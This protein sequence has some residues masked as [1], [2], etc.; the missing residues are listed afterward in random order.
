MRF[1]VEKTGRQGEREFLH[2]T[3]GP[4]ERL[5]DL[6]CFAYIFA[7]GHVYV[8]YLPEPKLPYILKGKTELRPGLCGGLASKISNTL[9]KDPIQRSLHRE[10]AGK[11]LPVGSLQ[12]LPVALS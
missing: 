8:Q 10:S 3:L 9:R 1:S 11:P 4:D 2:H 12:E 7:I 6:W 5:C